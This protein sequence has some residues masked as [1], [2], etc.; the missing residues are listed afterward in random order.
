[1]P[2]EI[3]I[4]VTDIEPISRLAAEIIG[5]LGVIVMLYG[6]VRSAYMFILHIFLKRYDLPYIR[7][8][9]GKYL[10]L[11]LEFL[12]GKD[13]IES[14]ISPSWDDLG[15]LGAII[16]LRCIITLF[17]WWELKEVKEEIKAEN[18]FITD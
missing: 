6:A 10:A 11:G 17:L 8:N 15:K 9:L 4:F 5:Y 3:S 1:M 12:I 13:I 7:I 2:A 18:Q 14:L 16:V